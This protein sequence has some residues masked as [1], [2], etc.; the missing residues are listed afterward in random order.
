M[1]RLGINGT[2]TVVDPLANGNGLKS[3][4]KL[5]LLSSI[6]KSK[7]EGAEKIVLYAPEGWGKTTWA[8]QSESPIF[9]STEGGLKGVKVDCFPEPKAWQ[10]IFD[11]VE[12]LRSKPHNFNTLVLDTIDWTE[13]LCHAFLLARDKHSSIEDYGYGKGYVLAFEEWKRLLLPLQHLR[14]EKD[15]NVIVLAH[16]SIK[17]FNNPSG[18]NYDRYEMKTDKRIS[19]LIREWADCVLFGN[20]DIAVDVKK[21]Q[22]KGKGYGGDRVIYTSH[23]A[24]WDAKNRYGLPEQIDSKFETFWNHVKGGKK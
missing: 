22:Q 12:E 8:S 24:A 16:S 23:S 18:E 11:A 2:A 10:D 9:I 3:I 13:H 15:M 14:D 4:E 20:Y 21:G 17:M 6:R 7:P 19:A 5:M 1:K